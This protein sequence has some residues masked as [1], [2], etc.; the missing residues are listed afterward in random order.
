MELADSTGDT[1]EQSYQRISVKLALI[2]AGAYHSKGH[3]GQWFF[4][5]PSSATAKAFVQKRLLDRAKA[6]ECTLIVVRSASFWDVP[7]SRNVLVRNASQARGSYLL[8]N[9]RRAII[10]RILQRD[11]TTA[12]V[13]RGDRG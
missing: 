9:E 3:P 7:E 5:L 4:N 6:N 8:M 1:I 12:D 13:L 10:D 11:P 2:E